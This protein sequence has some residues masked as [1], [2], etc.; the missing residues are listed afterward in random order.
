MPSSKAYELVL[1]CI[2]TEQQLKDNGYP[3]PSGTKGKAKLYASRF[4]K[5]PHENERYCSRCSTIFKLDI[6][7]EP[8]VDMCNYHSKST[9]YRR[10]KIYL[11]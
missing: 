9:G 6:Y 4:S 2:L 7:D 3:R 10:G 11:E 1:E 8:A 5:P